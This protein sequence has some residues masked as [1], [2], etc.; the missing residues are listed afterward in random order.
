MTLKLFPLLGLSK[1]KK[2]YIRTTKFPLLHLRCAKTPMLAQ[3]AV[4]TSLCSLRIAS[5][6][7]DIRRALSSSIIR[8]KNIF[9]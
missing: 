9:Q 6:A 8:C 5:K 2:K 1:K 7:V 3:G 4:E